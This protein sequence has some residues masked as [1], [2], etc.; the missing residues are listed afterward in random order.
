MIGVG[1]IG[2]GFMGRN[3][4]N[5]YEQ[6]KG[7]ARIVAVCDTQP[8]RLA[9]DWSKVG[10][11]VGDAQ[12]S[13]RDLTGMRPYPDYQDLIA[14]PDVQMVDICLPTY[15]HAEAAIAAL[16]AGKHVRWP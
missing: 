15:L 4:F 12:G 9:G 8:D 10:G 16:K 14:D 3:H 7:R 5:Q 6:Q 1:L 11:N 2:L 13:Q